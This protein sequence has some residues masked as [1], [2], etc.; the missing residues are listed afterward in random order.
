VFDVS[1]FDEI[2]VAMDLKAT[3][4]Q[5]DPLVQLDENLQLEQDVIAPL[6]AQR[7]IYVLESNDFWKQIK[8][9]ASAVTA[10]ALYLKDY[11]KIRPDLLSKGA[12]ITGPVFI[13][14]SAVIDPTAKVGPNVAIGAGVT[15]GEGARI[16]NAILL[17]NS[18]ID[19]HT[20]VLN[21][22]IG[23][24]C[25]LGQWA[26]V[27]GEPEPETAV[28]GQISVS[29]LASEVWVAPETHIRSCIVLPNKSLGKSAA[30]QVLL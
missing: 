20:V 7:K 3:R 5:N 24:D 18:L 27:D 22:I 10:N 1:L 29:V 14:D 12:N 19:K 30:N 6:A 26:R 15:V 16:A 28:K 9:A 8:T 13:D 11:S 25:R 21:S 23:S 4:A 17:E 2:K